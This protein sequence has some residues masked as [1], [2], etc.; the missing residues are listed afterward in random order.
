MAENSPKTK[1]ISLFASERILGISLYRVCSK[2]ESQ[3][4][5]NM[6]RC[7]F[8]RLVMREIPVKPYNLVL[9]SLFNLEQGKVPLVVEKQN[10]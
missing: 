8:C 4:V 2:D 9:N 6:I 5:I 1:N 10:K 3:Q 7:R